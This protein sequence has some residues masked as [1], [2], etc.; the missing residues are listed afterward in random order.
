MPELSR[1]WGRLIYDD[2]APQAPS[3]PP[4]GA[5]PE[6]LTIV[7]I[8]GTACDA[9]DWAPVTRL[10]ARRRR[11]IVPECAGHARA[12]APRVDYAFQD[13][14]D[15]IGDLVDG[16]S[17]PPA[18]TLLV[19][20]SLGGMVAMA[21]AQA[22]PDFAGVVSLEGWIHLR[23]ASAC[24]PEHE[25]GS[26]DPEAVARVQ[27]KSRRLTERF[28]PERW[29]HFRR[30][31]AAW[32]ASDFVASTTMPVLHVYGALGLPDEPQAALGVPNRPPH[33]WAVVPNTG[34]YLPHEAP[35]EVAAL[36]E[37]FADE[38]AG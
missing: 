16:L 6:R 22:R 29:D 18:R 19:G 20:H 7:L 25:L 15:D 33:R 34:H 1:P 21:L 13:M 27:A 23:A 17:L 5:S 38:L 14:V 4:S 24:G 32:D 11:V 2:V 36:I 31:V 26:L 30:T 12:D 35:V 8:H 28:G 37:T 9:E 3:D 10:L